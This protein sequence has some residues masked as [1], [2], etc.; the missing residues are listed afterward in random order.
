M[1]FQ[2]TEDDVVNVLNSHN[3]DLE[4]SMESVMLMIDDVEIDKAALSVDI[5]PEDDDNDILMKQTEAAYD[6]IAW[7][8]FQAG[9][10]TENQISKYGNPD[11][12]KKMIENQ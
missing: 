6:E 4:D 11:L 12:L 9:F 5:D 2:I 1:A 7:Q 10:I 3:V 8:L